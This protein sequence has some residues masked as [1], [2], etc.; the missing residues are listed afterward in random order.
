MY[1]DTHTQIRRMHTDTQIYTDMH[2]GQAHV[3]G[4]THT[5]TQACTQ[6]RHKYIMDTY[7]H[8]HRPGTST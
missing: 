7:V 4:H 5:H 8:T 2:T 3:H 6:A 1:T